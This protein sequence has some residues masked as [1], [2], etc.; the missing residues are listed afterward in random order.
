MEPAD[1]DGWGR[2]DRIGH[3]ALA[4]EFVQEA[5]LG[6]VASFPAVVGAHA[7]AGVA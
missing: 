2:P 7:G 5:A 1:V 4:L 3:A 6:G